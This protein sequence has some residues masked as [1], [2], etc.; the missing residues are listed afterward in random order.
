MKEII[1]KYK[2]LLIALLIVAISISA[3]L[4]FRNNK[5]PISTYE[6]KIEDFTRTVTASGRVVPS[7]EVG[8]SFEASARITNILVNVGDRVEVGQT[9]AVLDSSE[10]RDKINESQINLTTQIARLKKVE[11]D[12]ELNNQLS[13]QRVQLLGTINKAYV[14]ADDIVK[15]KI[16]LFIEN[17]NSRF[18][19]F[20][21][22]LVDYFLRLEIS[23]KRYAV[24]NSLADWKDVIEA[25]NAENVSASD[26]NYAVEKVNEVADL[27]D[28]ISG[29]TAKFE[30]TS[31]T[32]KAQ[33]DAYITNISASRNTI[34]TTSLELKRSIESLQNIENEVPV[35]ISNVSGAEASISSLQTI[36]GKY[37]L[38]SPISG[39]VTAKNVQIGELSSMTQSS[40]TI[41]GDSELEIEIF[42]PEILIEGVANYNKGYAVLDAFG[43]DRKFNVFVSQIEPRETIKDGITT[44][45]TTLNFEKN[46]EDLRPGMTVEVTIIKE[47]IENVVLIPNHLIVRENDKT[48]VDLFIGSNDRN[49]QI[50]RVEIDLGK[51]DGKGKSIVNSGVSAGDK[52][53]IQNK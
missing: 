20:D 51:T 32:T 24:G 25:L 35:L 45:K 23:E 15:N 33:I 46:I 47:E 2:N 5:S 52:I 44:Y 14:T 21:N 13:N 42:I 48:Y 43:R 4:L 31:N 19:S 29:G 41:I 49:D 6:A 34:A 22:S 26:A 7:K 27:L 17:P 9:I 36:A 10:I 50:K 39:V 3:L 28:T 8:L 1:S 30:P 38:R 12:D 11:S 37:T 53:V 18:P 16:D 40:F